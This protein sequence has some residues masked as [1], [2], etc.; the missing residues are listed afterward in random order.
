MARFGRRHHG[1][2]QLVG[3][4]QLSIVG[5][6]GFGLLKGEAEGDKRDTNESARERDEK[7]VVKLGAAG[8]RVKMMEFA[9]LL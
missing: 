1:C 9:T 3:G 4:Q 2:E 8:R 7:R 5:G 6:G